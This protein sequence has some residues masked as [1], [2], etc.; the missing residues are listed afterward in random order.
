MN[1]AG[2][3][4]GK[5]DEMVGRMPEQQST[6]ITCQYVIRTECKRAGQVQCA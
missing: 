6:A 5:G 2:C 4:D 1:D 3:S